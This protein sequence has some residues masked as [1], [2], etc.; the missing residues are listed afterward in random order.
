M[1][2][3]TITEEVYCFDCKKWM[4]L[5]REIY[6]VGGQLRCLKE[7]HVV[8]YEKDL[9]GIFGGMNEVER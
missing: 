2:Y 1:R 6:S 9:K 3:D 7:D 4:K 8:G 5:R